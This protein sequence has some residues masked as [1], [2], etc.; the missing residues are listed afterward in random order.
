MEIANVNSASS[1]ES[2]Q[3]EQVANVHSVLE[4]E[5]APIPHVFFYK[6]DSVEGILENLKSIYEQPWKHSDDL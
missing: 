3:F 1:G 4:S 6:L 2:S 5:V